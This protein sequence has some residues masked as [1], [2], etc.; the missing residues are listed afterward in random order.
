MRGVNPTSYM[1]GVQ[2][3]LWTME[4]KTGKPAAYRSSHAEMQQLE[5]HPR[6]RDE[7]P[8]SGTAEEYF[9]RLARAFGLYA[10]ADPM[11]GGLP[12]PAH[13]GSD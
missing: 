10:E 11:S 12:L 7:A 6:W 4:K 9:I 13:N 8:D 2:T 5:M 1:H 3:K